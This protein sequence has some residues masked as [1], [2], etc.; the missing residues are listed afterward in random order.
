MTIHSPTNAPAHQCPPI[1]LACANASPNNPP[2]PTD[3]RLHD[4]SRESL[5][6]DAW[7]EKMK[8]AS[9]LRD[10]E[11]D[12]D[13]VTR[14]CNRIKAFFEGAKHEN[15]WF[16]CHGALQLMSNYECKNWIEQKGMLKHWI[17]PE[18]GLNAGAPYST[19][20]PGSSPEAM[21]LDCTL[22]KD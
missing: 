2:P 1:L 22:L 11:C 8:L 14:T 7:E 5:R 6:S 9:R 4:N 19:H 21:P 13:V 20:P 12:T 10:V 17:L 18:A 3:H 15:E 16:F